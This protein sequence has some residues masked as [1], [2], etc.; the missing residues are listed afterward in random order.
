MDRCVEPEWLDTLPATDPGAIHSRQDLRRLNACMGH[1]RIVAR[2]LQKAFP[3]KPP[4]HILDLG[5]G[6]GTFLLKV[7]QSIGSCWQG[8]EAVIV[9][10]DD[11]LKSETRAGFQAAGWKIEVV[12]H[13]AIDYLRR[14]TASFR[15]VMIANLV[16]HHFPEKDLRS[17]FRLVQTATTMFLAVEPRRSALALAFSRLVWMIGGNAVTR[18]DAPASVLAGFRGS[19]LSQLWPTDEGWSLEERAAGVFSHLFVARRIMG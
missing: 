8:I 15:D 17:L 3:G 16:V 11:L 12:A 14:R 9:D 18:H 1:S 19:E 7:C 4:R 13:D 2:Q 5:G 6:D 10:R